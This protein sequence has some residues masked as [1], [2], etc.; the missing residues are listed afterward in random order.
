MDERA[1]VTGFLR[2]GGDVLLLRRSDEVGS[3][4]RKWGAVAGYAEGDPD[5]QVRVE[6]RE[7]T[8]L[9]VE[10]EVS[11]VRSGRPVAFA[12]PECDRE[13]AVHP[14]LFD[15]DTREIELSEEHDAAEWVP[16]TVLCEPD[17]GHDRDRDR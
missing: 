3:Y 1:V 8:G 13:W 4:G 7:E 11:L 2:T 14:Y 15:C 12:D 16:P 17:A 5:E 9:D 6:I 10:N